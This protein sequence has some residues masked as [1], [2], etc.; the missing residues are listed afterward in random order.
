MIWRLFAKSRC[1]KDPSS[2]DF[3]CK[4]VFQ[5]IREIPAEMTFLDVAKLGI[6]RLL[7]AEITYSKSHSSLVRSTYNYLCSYVNIIIQ[8][9]FNKYTVRIVFFRILFRMF[10][11]HVSN[12][13]PRYLKLFLDKGQLFFFYGDNNK[14]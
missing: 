13:D 1:L 2:P 9:A 3:L 14:K 7:F 5:K 10:L 12:V 6:V 4:K 8:C 11:S